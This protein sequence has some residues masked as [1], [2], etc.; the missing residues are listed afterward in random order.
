MLPETT[1]ADY[2]ALTTVAGSLISYGGKHF[3]QLM[4]LVSTND[5]EKFRQMFIFSV[6][7]QQ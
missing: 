2:F 6:K 4:D 1:E 3:Y 5:L 7:K